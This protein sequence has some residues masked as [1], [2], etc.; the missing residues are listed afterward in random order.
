MGYDKIESDLMRSAAAWLQRGAALLPCQHESKH[1]VR[2]FGQYQKQITTIPEARHYF[3]RG[4]GHNLAVC[5]PDNLVCLDFDSEELFTSW[6]DALPADLCCTYQETTR[7]GWH[8]F[9]KL[10]EPPGPLQLVAGVE[11]KRVVLVY[12]SVLPGFRY[13]PIDHNA[14][15]LTLSPGSWSD[16]VSL[17]LSKEVLP[18]LEPLQRLIPVGPPP[19]TDDLLSQI[20]QAFPILPIAAS[21]T[22]LRSSDGGHGRWYVG[23]CPFHDD[24]NPSFWVDAKRGLWGC[25]AGCGRGDVINLFAQKHKLNMLEA[26]KDLA[27]QLP[28]QGGGR[29]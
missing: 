16:V 20:K 10:Q 19:L 1:L 29:R 6:E 13:W 18:E 12:P 28:G 27:G 24:K 22:K 26:I 9:Y 11:I 4:R 17:L 2:G 15:L 25:R 5:L 3:G 21:L 23:R 7:R 14:E 8:V